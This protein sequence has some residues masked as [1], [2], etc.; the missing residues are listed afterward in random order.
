M[1][2]SKHAKCKVSVYIASDQ[3][4]LS[5]KRI[6]EGPKS[7]YVHT[8]INGETLMPKIRSKLGNMTNDEDSVEYTVVLTDLVPPDPRPSS[9]PRYYGTI[10][11]AKNVCVPMHIYGEDLLRIISRVI[12][13]EASSLKIYG[14]NPI[15]KRG[16]LVTNEMVNKIREEMGI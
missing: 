1:D 3:E 14:L 16:T 11:F 12:G 7:I 15:P 4:D 8:A 2:N 10:Y 5:E 13:I 6:L 9:W